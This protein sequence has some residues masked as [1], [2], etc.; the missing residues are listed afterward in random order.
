LYGATS[1]FCPSAI[2]ETVAMTSSNGRCN[3]SL[4]GGVV[5]VVE[6]RAADTRAS[7]LVL[8]AGATEWYEMM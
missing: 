3:T 2:D 1:R 7:F 8:M 6:E 4:I 5:H